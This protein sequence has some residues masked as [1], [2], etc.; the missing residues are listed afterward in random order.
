MLF[1]TVGE[2]HRHPLSS[3]MNHFSVGQDLTEKLNDRKILSLRWTLL[4]Q[5]L[6]E[7]GVDFVGEQVARERTSRQFTKEQI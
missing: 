6:Q 7:L 3:V 2:E 4:G 1:G 5:R